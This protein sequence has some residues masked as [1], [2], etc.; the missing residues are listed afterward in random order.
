M[1]HSQSDRDNVFDMKTIDGIKG[2]II[3]RLTLGSVFLALWGTFALAET[4]EATE[5]VGEGPGVTGSDVYRDSGA[6]GGGIIIAVIDNGFCSLTVSQDSGDAPSWDSIVDT[7]DFKGG[8]LMDCTDDVKH[9]TKVVENILDHA[10]GAKYCLY[11][12]ASG[13]TDASQLQ[14]AVDA[15][16]EA[17]A[18]VISMSVLYRNQGWEDGTGGACAALKTAKDAG[19]LVFVASGN[20]ALQHWRGVFNDPDNNDLHNWSVGDEYD[21]LTLGNGASVHATLQWDTSTGAT[22]YDLY[23]YNVTEDSIIDSSTQPGEDYEDLRYKNTTGAA[24]AVKLQVRK[25]SGDSTNM[26]LFATLGGIGIPIEYFTSGGSIGSPAS[27]DEPNVISVGAV[28]DTNYGVP[29]YTSGIIKIYSGR[30]PT[31][32]GRIEPDVVAPTD[33]S[34]NFAGLGGTSGAA[35]NATGTAAA[36]WSSVPNYSA[37][38]VR[39]LLLEMAE[40]FKDWGDTGVD[41]VYG[42]G[43]I[44]LHTYHANTIWVDQD[45][46][47][48]DGSDTIPYSHVSHA[49]DSATAGGRVVFLGDSYPE[50]IVL[51]KRLLYESIGGSAVV[52]K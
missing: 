8:G 10:P 17:G 38:G 39:Y 29:L 16:V 12:V 1:R 6:N 9:G 51:N 2:L 45:A 43:G 20:S 5:V 14:Q 37:T 47:N 48:S 30:G 7:A 36:F 31:N 49:Q 33:C 41:T 25:V 13:I 46:G 50:T 21:G 24:Q 22:N 40:I 26:Q 35:P 15:A 52:G 42:R 4:K 3:L 44:R 32:S 27:S 19:I 23:L 34:T 18:D 28:A 11:K